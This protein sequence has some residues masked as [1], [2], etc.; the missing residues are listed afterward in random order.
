MAVTDAGQQQA[1]TDAPGSTR[2]WAARKQRKAVLAVLRQ[3]LLIALVIPGA[4]LFLTPWA[5]MISTAG[6]ETA[7]I[8]R[9][10]PVWIPPVFHWENFIEA[11]RMGDFAIYY[12][13]TAFICLLDVVGV[14]VSSSLAAYAF[15]RL[16]FPGRNAL[17]VIVLSTMM[18]PGQVTM[19][20]LYVFFSKLGW[21]NTLKP[22]TIPYFFGD[23]FSIFLLRQFFLTISREMD[24]AARIDGCSRIGVFMRILVPLTR[25]ALAVVGIF[26]LTWAWN[27][28]MGPLIY[29]NSPR[30][31]TITLGL[32]RFV[33]R[34]S[35][36]IQYL[37]AMTAVSTM[38]PIIMFFAT[39]RYF[40][41]GIV[42]TGIKG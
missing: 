30:L 35:T 21:V 29:L 24:D 32:R 25:P 4:L 22:L 1:A 40:I 41:Q 13:N 28:F 2:L 14:I 38:V 6:K 36:D 31:F 34:T 17:F 3:V 10:P 16:R 7:Y 37:M 42:I 23:A 15:A 33:G 39:Q 11:W 5:W 12:R 8:W 26:T 9:M 18:L 27:D 19:I 20:P